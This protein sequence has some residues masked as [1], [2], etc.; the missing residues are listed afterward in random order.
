MYNSVYK[1]RLWLILSSVHFGA[2]AKEYIGHW[3]TVLVFTL[4]KKDGILLEQVSW[5]LV[6]F[7]HRETS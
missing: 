3:S 4:I 2:K 7:Q 1:P 6:R 5:T